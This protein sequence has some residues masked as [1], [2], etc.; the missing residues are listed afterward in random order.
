MAP[1]QVMQGGTGGGTPSQIA[2]AVQGAL[3]SQN[4]GQ[5]Q[6][7]SGWWVLV[8]VMASIAVSGTRVA[9]IAAGIMSIATI[10]QLQQWVSN[11]GV[12]K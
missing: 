12:A 11:K 7:T 9:F 6:A 8:A 4:Q 2:T 1:P 3:Q 10:Y 5:N